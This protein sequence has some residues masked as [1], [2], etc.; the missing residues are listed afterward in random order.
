[1]HT[2]LMLINPLYITFL[3]MYCFL[4]LEEDTNIVRVGN[5]TFHPRQVLGHGAEG[6]I[7]YK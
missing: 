1:M 4:V 5:I 6:T 7:V 2:L 3:K